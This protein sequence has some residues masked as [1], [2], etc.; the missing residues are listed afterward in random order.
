MRFENIRVEESVQFAS[1]W[2]NQAVWTSDAERGKIEDVI[3]RNI[4]VNNSGYPLNK[5]FEF[6]GYDADH[7]ITNVLIDNVVINGRKVTQEDVVINPR[8]RT[9]VVMN[10][11]VYDVSVK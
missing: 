9:G 6:I 8:A 3:F 10:D 7:A 5:E 11:Y 1:L 4:T 2:I